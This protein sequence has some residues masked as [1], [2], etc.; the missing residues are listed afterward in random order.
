MSSGL[1]AR[2]TSASFVR[3]L[4]P[5][6]VVLL[7]GAIL[8]SVLPSAQAQSGSSAAE[9]IPTGTDGK[10]GHRWFQPEPLV[11]VQLCRRQPAATITKPEPTDANRL[12]IFI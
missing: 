11:Q 12:D 8:M 1:V 4:T 9:A 10:F 2:A 5:W 7:V 3:R 6:A